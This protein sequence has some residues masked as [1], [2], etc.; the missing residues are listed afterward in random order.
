M[1]VWIYFSFLVTF[2]VTGKRII[3]QTRRGWTIYVSLSNHIFCDLGDEEDT[4]HVSTKMRLKI[5][6]GF[7]KYGDILFN[8][9]VSLYG[10]DNSYR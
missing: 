1:Y 7:V 10:Y 5:Y 4:L 8:D 2:L 3:D 9:L 6:K